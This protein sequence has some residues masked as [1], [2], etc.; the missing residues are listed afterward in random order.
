MHKG[1]ALSLSQC[2]LNGYNIV[3][4]QKQ[5]MF[6]MF[7]ASLLLLLSFACGVSYTSQPG[8]TVK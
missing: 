6:N 1:V 4:D 7:L 5:D 8:A 3:I 2:N